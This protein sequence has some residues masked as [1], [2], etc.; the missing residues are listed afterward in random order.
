[1]SWVLPLSNLHLPRPLAQVTMLQSQPRLAPDSLASSQKGVW[2]LHL[3]TEA[4]NVA[5]THMH[6]G[7][8]C[9]ALWSLMLG[10]ALWAAAT[11][12]LQHKK[13]SSREK[14]MQ[15][16]FHVIPSLSGGLAALYYSSGGCRMWYFRGIKDTPVTD[17]G[18]KLRK[19]WGLFWTHC[20]AQGIR[21]TCLNWASTQN[22]HLYINKLRGA[23]TF[24]GAFCTSPRLKDRKGGKLLSWGW[25]I[26]RWDQKCPEKSE[27][28]CCF[29]RLC[30]NSVFTPFPLSGKIFELLC[31]MMGYIFTVK[32]P[33]LLTVL[34][35]HWA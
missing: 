26:T 10:G 34:F 3:V 35:L 27:P 32:I 28:F 12:L 14:S 8:S 31:L 5:A 29:P 9:C 6:K 18:Q 20:L 15:S 22:S 25:A 30:S 11:H 21:E 19:Q 33:V 7:S 2:L 13:P 16:K 1:M 17:L 24:H 4:L 23:Q